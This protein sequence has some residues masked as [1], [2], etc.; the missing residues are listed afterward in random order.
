[1]ANQ[2]GLFL[3]F[4]DFRTFWGYR[5]IS[6]RP[7]ISVAQYNGFTFSKHLHVRWGLFVF[8]TGHLSCTWLFI[9]IGE[10]R[11]WLRD[12]IIKTVVTWR[13]WPDDIHR[14][15]TQIVVTCQSTL[16]ND[17]T[18]SHTYTRK[19]TSYVVRVAWVLWPTRVIIRSLKHLEVGGNGWW[20]E[21]DGLSLRSRIGGY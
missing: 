2:S 1:M 10:R 13:G 17:S 20:Q 15:S 7:R 5:Q 6:V 16:S 11:C 12:N 18:G 4:S 8:W 9:E 19:R 21:R 3:S 14:S